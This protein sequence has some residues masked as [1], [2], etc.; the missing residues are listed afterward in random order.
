METC[1][2]K[3]AQ[4]HLHKGHQSWFGRSRRRRTWS[5]QIPKQKVDYYQINVS[6]EK[7]HCLLFFWC[8]SSSRWCAKVSA[9]AREFEIPGNWQKNSVYD[10]QGTCCHFAFGKSCL[11][12]WWHKSS[13]AL[14]CKESRD[15]AIAAKTSSKLNNIQDPTRTGIFWKPIINDFSLYIHIIAAGRI[16]GTKKTQEPLR[17]PSMKGKRPVAFI[18]D[19]QVSSPT[20]SLQS[21]FDSLK[22][23]RHWNVFCI[24]ATDEVRGGRYNDAL[25]NSQVTELNI[26]EY[27]EYIAQLDVEATSGN[28]YEDSIRLY[29]ALVT[30]V[31]GSAVY[32]K[33][34]L[35]CSGDRFWIFHALF[36]Q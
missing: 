12:R 32:F 8:S 24:R 15:I 28:T 7:E 19:K 25:V 14:S 6:I 33:P 30:T 36:V 4:I 16:T 31:G 29:G 21:L 20:Y 18:E 26:K 1:R 17:K 13:G 11:C 3:F 27:V 23:T 35:A 9:I 2:I 10:F 34:S 5:I 22:K